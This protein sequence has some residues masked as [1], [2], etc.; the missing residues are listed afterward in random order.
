MAA[1]VAARLEAR[2]RCQDDVRMR[3]TDVYGG[4]VQVGKR[5]YDTPKLQLRLCSLPCGESTADLGVVHVYV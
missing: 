5:E 4:G 2:S 3:K 1:A